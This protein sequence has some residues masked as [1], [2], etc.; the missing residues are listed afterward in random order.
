MI[1]SQKH[2]LVKLEDCLGKG[3]LLAAVGNAD[4]TI[5]ESDIVDFTEV[6]CSSPP[7]T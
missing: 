4:A 2:I 6:S 5:I 7:S 3:E 1:R